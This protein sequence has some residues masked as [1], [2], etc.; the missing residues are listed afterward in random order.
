M[1]KI[2]KASRITGEYKLSDIKI[3][4][5]KKTNVD[6]G[7]DNTENNNAEE[8]NNKQAFI[9]REKILKEAKEKADNFISEAK[10]K[11]NKII[12]QAENKAVK[13]KEEAEKEGYDNGY[14]NGKEAGHKAGYDNGYQEAK[15][16]FDKKLEELNSIIDNTKNYLEEEIERL[17][18]EVIDLSLS[19]ASKI[20]NKEINFEPEIINNIIYDILDDIGAAHEDITIKV[21][22]D[23]IKYINEAELESGMGQQTL[24][25]VTD[26]NLNPGDCIVE[27]E[28]GGKDATIANKL[29]LIEDKLYQGADYNEES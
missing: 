4:N 6:K 12:E 9:E 23:M 28:F 22:P 26:S 19:I 25:F 18:A 8:N 13:I 21:S 14:Q 20:V 15:K 10:N 11:A 5:K 1:S 27:T 16:E 3:E 7:E 29:E 24:E 17:P 2:I